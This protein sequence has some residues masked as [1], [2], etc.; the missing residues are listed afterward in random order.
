MEIINQIT[1]I[2]TLIIERFQTSAHAKK[3]L[4]MRT[5]AYFYEHC[6]SKYCDLGTFTYTCPKCD[7][8]L[9]DYEIWWKDDEIYGGQPSIFECEHCKSSLIVE[10]DKEEHGYY[11]SEYPK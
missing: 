3:S 2:V 6:D 5:Q 9:D 4:K 1:K 11:V 8:R 7:R 10:Y